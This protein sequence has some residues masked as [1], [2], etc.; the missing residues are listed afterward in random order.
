MPSLPTSSGCGDRAVNPDKVKQIAE[1][2]KAIGLLNPIY[3][4]Y[5]ADASSCTLVAGA[6]RLAAAKL[7][8]WDSIDTVEVVGDSL[9]AQLAE[10]DENLCRSELTPAQ[11]VMHIARRKEVWEAMRELEK[12][13]GK[14]FPTSL[15][16]GRKAGPP[17][18]SLGGD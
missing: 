14:S 2:M 3:V 4:S 10:I 18:G 11:Y 13:G 5:S 7:L 9:T 17:Q 12:V 8:G 15:P 6:H 16:D 1:S